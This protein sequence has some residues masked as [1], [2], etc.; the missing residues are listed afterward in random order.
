[1]KKQVD[2]S[3]YEF[4]R[5]VKKKRWNSMWHQLD[6]VL[7]FMPSSVLEIG[8]GPGLFKAAAGAFDV[9]VETLD[10]DPDLKPDYLASVLQMP[11]ADESYDVV[12]AFQFLEHLP[13]EQTLAAFREMARVAKTG[14]VFSVPDARPVWTYMIHIPKIGQQHFFVSRPFSRPKPHQ[15]EGEHYWEINKQGF[16]LS[17]IKADFSPAGWHLERTYRV[18]ENPFHRFFVYRINH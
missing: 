14:I 7:A 18:F 8:P 12:C 6:E 11:F 10:I 9:P 3:H 15:F 17:K 13:Y 4:H 1:M 5:Y 16:P 2:K